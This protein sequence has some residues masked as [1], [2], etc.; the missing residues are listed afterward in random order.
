MTTDQARRVVKQQI[1]NA[2]RNRI[3]RAGANDKEALAYWRKKESDLR[4]SASQVNQGGL[5]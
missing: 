5:K 3:V 2:V 4:R 1:E